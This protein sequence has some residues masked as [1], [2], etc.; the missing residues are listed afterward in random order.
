MLFNWI[1]FVLTKIL[2]VMPHFFHQ[3]TPNWCFLSG[4]GIFYGICIFYLFLNIKARSR[5]LKKVGKICLL[6]ETMEKL[7]SMWGILQTRAHKLL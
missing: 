4:P 6:P 2:L 3:K 7:K 5:D 1:I